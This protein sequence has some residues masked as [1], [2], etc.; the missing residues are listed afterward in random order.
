MS[1]IW[2]FIVLIFLAGLYTTL[3]YSSKQFTEGFSGKPRCPD[4]LIQ[5]G[6]QLILK[7]SSLAEIPGVNPVRFNDLEEY[8]EFLTWQ[9][10]QGIDCPVLYFTKSYDAQS[11]EGYLP[12]PL[13]PIPMDINPLSINPLTDK[14]PMHSLTYP[15]MDTHNQDIGSQ[16]ALEEYHYVG[17]TDPISAN[18]AD[19]NWGG[20]TFSEKAIDQQFYKG[21]EVY[22]QIG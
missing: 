5:D 2:I 4:V 21:N 8:A 12:T 3:N 22:K 19:T 9:R 7:N 13:P 16:T 14:P 20:S 6:E 18:A 11:H 1:Y 10:S 17:K 15:R